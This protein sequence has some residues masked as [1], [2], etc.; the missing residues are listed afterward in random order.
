[1]FADDTAIAAD[2]ITPFLPDIKATFNTFHDYTGL[3]MNVKKS[4]IVATGGRKYLRSALDAVGWK[5][6]RVSGKERYLGTYIGHEVTLEDIFCPVFDK[7]KDKLNHYIP[8]KHHH[9]LQNRVIIW[10]TWLLPIFSYVFNLYTIPQDYL[11]WMDKLCVSWLGKGNTMK[12]LYLSRPTKLA[13]LT[14]PL[15]DTTI[16]NYSALAARST[17]YT[18]YSDSSHWTLRVASHRA[19][20][21]DFLQT[22]YNID[23]ARCTTAAHYYHHALH[24]TSSSMYSNYRNELRRKLEMIDIDTDHHNFYFSNTSR[25]PSWVPS[26]ARLTNINITHNALFTAKRLHKRE[27]CYLCEGGDDS[28][29]HI[30]DDCPVVKRAHQ[31][32]WSKLGLTNPFNLEN[33]ICATPIATPEEIGAQYLFTDSVWRARNSSYHGLVKSATAWGGWIVDNALLRLQANKPDIFLNFFPRNSVPNRL[34]ITYSAN[35]GSSKHATAA[36]RATATHVVNAKLQNVPDGDYYAF[37]DG[38]ADPNPGPTGAGVAVYKKNNGSDDLVATIGAA[39][40]NGDNNAGELYAIGIA[41]D[42]ITHNTN[43]THNFHVFTDSSVV[44]GALNKGWAA[45]SSNRP[46]LHAVRK[47]HRSA[48]FTTEIHWIPGHSGI[49]QN[50]LADSIAGFGSAAAASENNLVINYSE[51]NFN[52]LDHSFT[53]S[54]SHNSNSHPPASHPLP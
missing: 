51:A 49:V 28:I 39:L 43:N 36:T 9:S 52:F 3:E 33:A 44:R 14:T 10:N 20:A 11:E 30:W 1:M 8:I 42:Y 15:R 54:H 32:F 17:D 53:Y 19:R 45:G 47:T 2:D 7:F 46:L 50:D 4:A 31:R 29:H 38:S 26:Y 18:D 12:S 16:A 48:V 27:N 5:K 6:L 22:E 13:G 25:V 23:T 35:M 34:K 41:I 21:R 24:S 40:G 37:T